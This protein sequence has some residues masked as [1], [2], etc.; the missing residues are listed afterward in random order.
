MKT[1]TKT[2]LR[3]HPI[4]VF[5]LIQTALGGESAS[6]PPMCCSRLS[7]GLALTLSTIASPLA[8]STRTPVPAGPMS[9]RHVAV[10]VPLLPVGAAARRRHR[11]ARRT[12]PD[13]KVH[14]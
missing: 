6:L 2:F 14:P 1:T 4:A 7:Q 9:R 5:Y 11:P 8:A 3:K 10:A 13:C 12:S